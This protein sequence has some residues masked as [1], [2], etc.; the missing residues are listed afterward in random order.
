MNPGYTLQMNYR[1]IFEE[2]NRNKYIFKGLLENIDDDEYLWKPNPDKWCLLE[3]ICHLRDEEVDDFR[4]RVQ[5]V[6]ETPELVL[7]PI[8]PVNWVKERNYIE[9]NYKRALNDFL[10]ERERSVEWLQ[11]LTDPKWDNQYQHPKLG[12]MSAKLFL[13]NWLAHDYLHIRQIVKVKF[14]YLIFISS[15]D[16]N[17]AGEW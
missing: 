12:P 8:D 2:L 3:I 14:D 15:E 4:T 5:Y 17:Y 7:P 13:S 6:L 10:R 16:L 9:Q 11:A 1:K